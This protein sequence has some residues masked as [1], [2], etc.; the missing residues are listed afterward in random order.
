MVAVFCDDFFDPLLKEAFCFV[1]NYFKEYKNDPSHD[2]LHI[3]RVVNLS[4]SNLKETLTEG[5]C[6]SHL[7][8][9]DEKSLV[10]L[11]FIVLFC[12]ILHDI[13]D[14]KSNHKHTAEEAI[15]MFLSSSKHQN[16]VTALVEIAKQFTLKSE[17]LSCAYGLAEL[18]KALACNVIEKI[19][20]R[21][22]LSE[23]CQLP[24]QQQMMIFGQS[25]E[26]PSDLCCSV[27]KPSSMWELAAWI[28]QDSDRLDAIGAIG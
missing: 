17:S 11:R 27:G 14:F 18:S 5:L 16:I 6:H 7:I 19:S 15:L 25:K 13:G 22:E 10:F 12:S 9:P 23:I 1:E 4:M 24:S 28:V 26:I 2:M 3:R 8:D 20:F 21:H